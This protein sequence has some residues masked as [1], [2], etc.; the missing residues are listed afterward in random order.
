VNGVYHLIETDAASLFIGARR[1]GQS[2]R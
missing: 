1:P 2:V